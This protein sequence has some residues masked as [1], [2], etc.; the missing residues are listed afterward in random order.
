MNQR[1]NAMIKT[2]CLKN[3]KKYSHKTIHLNDGVTLLVG[4]N[5]EGKS[6]LLH[7][8]AIWGFCV[9]YLKHT[10]GIGALCLGYGG[11]GVGMNIDDFSPINIPELKYAEF[12]LQMQQNSD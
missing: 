3:F 5:N 4:G 6:T 10:K 9:D 7:A 1:Y 2:V 12:N 11:T 8:L